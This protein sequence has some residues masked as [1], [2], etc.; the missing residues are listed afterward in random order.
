MEV[1]V[2]QP[3]S[4][5]TWLAS[6]KRSTLLLLVSRSLQC[7]SILLKALLNSMFGTQPA[8]KNWEDFVMGIILAAIVALSC[9]MFALASLIKMFL[10]GTKILSESARTYQSASLVIKSTW[11]TERSRRRIL[12]STAKRI[13]STTTSL[14]RATI[15]LKNPSSGSYDD[16]PSKSNNFLFIFLVNLTSHL[17]KPQF[18][19]LG[20][21]KLMLLKLHR[22]KV[23]LR[24]LKTWSYQ[25]R[26]TSDQNQ[27]SYVF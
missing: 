11:R 9:S 3:L 15:S 13:F 12:C 26:M 20:K 6:S 21:F 2:K 5:D 24:L 23:N 14:L 10:N 25:K 19:L 4:R 17:S 16:S 22:C 7:L 27:P 1:L 8:K 18:L